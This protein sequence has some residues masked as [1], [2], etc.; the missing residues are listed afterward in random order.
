M[1]AA[2]RVLLLLCLCA[3]AAARAE[4]P[5]V[6]ALKAEVAQIRAGRQGA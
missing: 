2:A 6:A 5:E 3:A 4:D 1:R